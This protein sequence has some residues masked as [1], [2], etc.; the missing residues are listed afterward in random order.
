M[1]NVA[2]G[3]DLNLLQA[4][5]VLV[6]E[7]SVTGAAEKLQVSAAT[8]SRTLSRLRETFH[9]AILVQSGRHMVP[10]PRALQM[11]PRVSQ[12]LS[13]ISDLYRPR[14]ALDFTG[15]TPTF[16][17]RAADVVIGPYAE[18]LLRAL[19]ADCPD[20][21]LIFTAESNSDD[22]DFLRQGGIDLYIG[23]TAFLRPEIMR[24]TLFESRFLGVVRAGHPILLGDITP[25]ALVAYDHIAVSRRG[26]RRGP[27][28]DVLS[29][30]YGLT[31]NV[32]LLLT[33]FY[34]A[35]QGL[36]QTDLV[37]PVPDIVINAAPLERLGLFAFPMPIDLNP[38][39][40]F[41]AWHPR[42]ENDQVHQWLRRTVTQ[43]MSPRVTSR[44]PAI[45][46]TK[47]EAALD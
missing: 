3:Y 40:I 5:N 34:A 42:H 27:I 35:L 39:A 26:R 30:Q 31:R 45:D 41:Q 36:S 22:S 7:S 16:R 33:S 4:M 38:V 8:M 24:Q 13:A 44:K 6:E 9:D 14:H 17:I 25:Q 10:T 18:A 29:D 11:Q 1:A 47:T 32:A 12:I 43:V 19:R 15:L 23:A 2:R 28:D 21:T 37:L 20:T 46:V